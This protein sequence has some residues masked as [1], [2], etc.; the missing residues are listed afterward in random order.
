MYTAEFLDA[1]GGVQER[2]ALG[3][4]ADPVAA[5]PQ[6]GILFEFVRARKPSV[7]RYRVL[8]NDGKEIARFGAVHA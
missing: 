4:L 6:A 5:D 7:V 3:M 1:T 2:I 8:D